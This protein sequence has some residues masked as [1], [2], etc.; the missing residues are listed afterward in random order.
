MP[1]GM[2]NDHMMKRQDP[3][4]DHPVDASDIEPEDEDPA[5]IFADGTGRLRS[6]NLR[7]LV[8]NEPEQFITRNTWDVDHLFELQVTGE[9][10]KS[11]KPYELSH[12][13]SFIYRLAK[14]QIDLTYSLPIGP[15]QPKQFSPK[16]GH[17]NFAIASAALTGREGPSSGQNMTFPNLFG[18]AVLK[19]L[20]ANQTRLMTGIVN[21]V[22]DQFQSIASNSNVKACF[23]SY[24][25][26]RYESCISILS[27]WTSK[28]IDQTSSTTSTSTSSPTITSASSTP[29]TVFCWNAQGPRNTSAAIA[30]SG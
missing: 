27:S 25:S 14:R 8:P 22:G 5:Q 7:Y 16:E 2:S 4:P 29:T 28:T 18:P 24:A 9:A 30:D 1:V 15:L 17:A 21:N 3:C 23:T 6:D 13:H 26:V 20:E 11:T 10:F 19:Y 12:D